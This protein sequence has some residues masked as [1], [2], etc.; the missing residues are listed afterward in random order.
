MALPGTELCEDTFGMARDAIETIT[1]F[2]PS[3]EA[4]QMSHSDAERLV[5]ARGH[6][7]RRK[8]FH[9]HVDSCGPGDATATIRVA[10]GEE[11]GQQ[12]PHERGLSTICGQIRVPCLGYEAEGTVSLHPLDAELTRSSATTQSAASRWISMTA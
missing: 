6:D 11:Q 12:R 5:Q 4:G 8:L 3:A 9:A 1:A 10:D 2:F 7:H